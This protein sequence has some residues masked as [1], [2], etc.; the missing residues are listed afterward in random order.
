M[1]YRHAQDFTMKGIHRV[2]IQKFSKRGAE[3]GGL[4]V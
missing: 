1:N 2:W 3:A 4:G